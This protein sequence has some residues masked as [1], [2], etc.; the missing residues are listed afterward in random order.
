MFIN[1]WINNNEKVDKI[2]YNI[3]LYFL[4]NVKGV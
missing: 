4:I 1:F 3:M 2:L